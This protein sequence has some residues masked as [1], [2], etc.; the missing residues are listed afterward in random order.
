MKLAALKICCGKQ[1]KGV[2]LLHDNTIPH[3]VEVMQE[4]LPNS[5]EGAATSTIPSSTM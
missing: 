4:P 2:I 3:S 5:I 1:R